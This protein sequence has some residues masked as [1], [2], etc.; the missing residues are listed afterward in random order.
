MQNLL[1]KTEDKFHTIKQ[2]QIKL[3]K[4]IFL[5]SKHHFLHPKY[6]SI[7]QNILLK[8]IHLLFKAYICNY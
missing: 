8:I 1:Y 7:K 2:L 3:L 6:N 5:E 4:Y